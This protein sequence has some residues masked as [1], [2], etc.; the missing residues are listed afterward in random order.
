MRVFLQSYITHVRHI[1]GKDNGAADYSSRTFDED[2]R[3]EVI[4]PQF[5]LNK[6]AAAV[7][8]TKVEN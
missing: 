5:L 7:S 8:A 6:I 1:P 2:K 3:E 4:L